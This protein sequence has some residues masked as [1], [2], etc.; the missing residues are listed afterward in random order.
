MDEPR[1]IKSSQKNSPTLSV[2][3]LYIHSALMHANTTI[4]LTKL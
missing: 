3:C 4:G 2:F 1:M